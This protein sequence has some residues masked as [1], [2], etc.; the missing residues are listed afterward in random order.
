MKHILA[1]M[2][3]FVSNLTPPTADRLWLVYQPKSEDLSSTHV[4]RL[5][6][7]LAQSVR[8]NAN[9]SFVRATDLRKCNEVHE[10]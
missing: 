6:A 1:R 5:E 8:K 2:S 7:F 10:C 3:T 9:P 4:A